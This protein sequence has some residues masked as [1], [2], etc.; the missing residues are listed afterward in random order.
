M[1]ALGGL[2][3]LEGLN[4]SRTLISDAGLYRLA[5]AWPGLPALASR[6]SFYGT[7]LLDGSGLAHLKGLKRLE[8][9]NLEG[10]HVSDAGLAHLAEAVNLK[11][12][13]LKGTAAGNAGVAQLKGLTN[14]QELTLDR[15]AITDA[16]L[17]ELASL[18][19]LVILSVQHTKDTEGAIDAIKRQRAQLQVQ[20]LAASSS[21]VVSPEAAIGELEIVH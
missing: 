10:T 9:L 12:L 2:I 8:E 5:T 18:P 13:Q 11:I 3:K 4:L 6:L 1:P 7:R 21:G 16:A 14:L 20:Q 17:T 15:T 19:H